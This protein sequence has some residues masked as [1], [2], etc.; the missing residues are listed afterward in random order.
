MNPRFLVETALLTHGSASAS[1]EDIL[2]IFEGSDAF[3][4]WIDN[5]RIKIGNI[6]EYIPIRKKSDHLIRINHT[7]IHEVIKSGGSGALTASGTMAVCKSM[8]IPLAVTCG[9]GG[10]D[11]NK[12]SPDL[13]ALAKMD[14][15]LIST[16]PK[17]MFDIPAT[18][19]WLKDSS[20]SIYGN[21]TDK[22]TGYIFSVANEKITPIPSSS[23]SLGKSHT[24]I[25]NPIDE[26]KR[27]NDMYILKK[28]VL[29]GIEAEQKGKYFHPAVNKEID[30]LTN[31]YSTVIQLSSLADNIR[32]A[33]ELTTNK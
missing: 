11:H 24:L 28:A 22:C 25:L 23:L 12:I 4:C 29:M 30:R 15:A 6:K 27:I 31:G 16:S 3:F 5:G 18:L 2:S 8:D 19:K 20:V 33:Q 17:D 1:N 13:K 9:M 26:H 21:N 10:I 32:L 7:M 14:V